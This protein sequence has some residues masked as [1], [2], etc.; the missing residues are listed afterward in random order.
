MEM[1]AYASVAYRQETGGI[2][3]GNYDQ[4]QSLASIK[5]I[6]GPTS[7]SRGSFSWFER[8]TRGLKKLLDENWERGFYYLG[9]WHFHPFN[10]PTPSGQD[11]QQ[12]Q[13]IAKST[14]YKCPEPILIIIGGSE[15]HFQLRAFV[16]IG[17]KKLIELYAANTDYD[18]NLVQQS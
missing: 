8:G 5:Q 17:S 14:I 10:S 11:I 4:G 13:D 7:D 2:L 15:E 18:D 3:I 6:T 16:S 1:E 12:M 9:E